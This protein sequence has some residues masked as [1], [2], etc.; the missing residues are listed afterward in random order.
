MLTPRRKMLAAG[1]DERGF[2]IILMALV[3]VVLMGA[4]TVAVD[5]GGRYALAARIQRTADAAVLAGVTVLPNGLGQAET[6]A[7]QVAAQ[8][9]FGHDPANGVTV[10]VTEIGPETLQVEITQDPVPE[11][12]GVLFGG[13]DSLTRRA[14][15]KFVRAVSL[16]SPRN[17][18]GTGDLIGTNSGGDM[19]RFANFS[20]NNNSVQSRTSAFQ[21]RFWLAISGECSSRE[22]GDRYNAV[23]TANYNNN[24]SWD[25]CEGGSTV[26]NEEF[27]NY[28]YIYAVSVPD[29]YASGTMDIQAFDPAICDSSRPGDP[30][31]AS[32]GG[33][34]TTYTIRT[35]STDPLAGTVVA[36]GNYA[37]TSN[38]CN[39][40]ENLATLNPTAGSTYFI[41]VDA[42][43]NTGGGTYS[44]G[45]ALRASVRANN[46]SGRFWACSSD[47]VDA[48]IYVDSCPQVYAVADMGV[49]ASLSGSRAEFF[50]SEIGPEYSGKQMVVTLFDPGEGAQTL[51]IKDPD[52]DYVAFDWQVDCA[53]VTH[54]TGGC[55]GS[56]SA[57]GG[58]G[59]GGDNHPQ[60]GPRRL[61][62]SKY[63]DR[64][65]SLTID[66]PD[67]IA[68]EYGGATW[69]KV[70]YEV[71]SS[72][73]DRTTWAVEVKGDPVRLLPNP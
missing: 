18:L 61:S 14:T 55:S 26:P 44:N 11:Y 33:M 23:S 36:S 35:G 16:G 25:R 19:R 46:S 69:W 60:P 2:A 5:L 10:T 3:L 22:N 57:N 58:L 17:F 37:R 7:R 13:P 53:G 63:N 62:D 43:R 59:L 67:D 49:F 54:P 1:P 34:T 24:G 72:P 29:G 4:A 9:E 68:D 47:P 48:D 56:A 39:S 8:N 6:E 30:S 52:G 51:R 50:L 70:E 32:S 31:N 71:G 73:T 65:L 40:W 64:A 12:F 15:A 27:R 20:G 38:G 41:Q 21:E 28:G 42:G 45:F 66:L